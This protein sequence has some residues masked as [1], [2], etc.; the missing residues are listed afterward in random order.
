MAQIILGPSRSYPNIPTVG[1]SLSSHTAALNAIVES[2]NIHERR[3]KDVLESF[4]RVSELATLGL[5]EIDGK[6]VSDAATEESTTHHHDSTYEAIDATLVRTSDAAWNA[7]DWDTAYAWGNHADA[8]YLTALSE[9]DPVFAASD[10]AAVTAAAIA[11]WNT[12]YGWGNHAGL[13]SL[14]GH[15]HDTRY[16]TE[17]E[18]DALIAGLGG[19]ITKYKTAAETLTASST[20]FQ[21]D[22]HL[23][24]FALTA[25]AYYKIEGY[26]LTSMS[27]A[28]PDI[29]L[30]LSFTNTPQNAWWT[31]SGDNSNGAASD[32]DHAQYTTTIV[33]NVTVAGEWGWHVSGYI[34]ANAT[35]GGTMT[36][37]WAKSVLGTDTLT[38]REGS[39]MTLTKMS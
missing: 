30:Q 14:S 3:T 12:A 35:T 36:V 38:M 29:K 18:V 34:K 11:N 33:L 16:Y 15:D 10:A 8:G 19:G 6:V 24:G 4:V 25:G 17:T 39:W 5:V 21:D 7:A 32:A 27:T 23:S 31:V 2:L 37:Q 1:D 13:Y 9:T 28:T 22:D 20:T 26:L